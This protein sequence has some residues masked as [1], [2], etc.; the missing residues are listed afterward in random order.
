MLSSAVIITVCH[1][2]VF[3][4]YAI[5]VGLFGHCFIVILNCQN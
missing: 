4:Q 3:A 2:T 5:P 1:Y